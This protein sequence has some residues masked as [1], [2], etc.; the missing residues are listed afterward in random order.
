M[1]VPVGDTVEVMFRDITM[2]DTTIRE[3][4][5][6][7]ITATIIQDMPHMEQPSGFFSAG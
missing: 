3:D 4:I 2:E 5:M 6:E 7:V 1:E